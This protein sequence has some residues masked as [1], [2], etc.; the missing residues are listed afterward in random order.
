MWPQILPLGLKENKE[1]ER[2]RKWKDWREVEDVE[3][4]FCTTDLTYIQLYSR[5]QSYL[6]TSLQS[7]PFCLFPSVY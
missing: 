5:Y 4:I 7:L 1:R 2:E 3:L 6:S